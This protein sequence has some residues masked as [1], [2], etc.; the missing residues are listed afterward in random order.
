[1]GVQLMVE[2]AVSAALQ[3]CDPRQQLPAGEFQD[4]LF[5]VCD[6]VAG[7]MQAEQRSTLSG[8]DRTFIERRVS[9]LVGTC[10]NEM[11]PVRFRKSDR[12][13]CKTGSDEHDWASGLVVVVNE[14]HPEDEKSRLPYVV[15]IVPSGRFI[16]VPKDNNCVCRAELCFG[17]R[18][19]ALWF[20]L[21]CLQAQPLR[22]AARRFEV[23][24]RV[25]C[26]VEDDSD[27][28]SIWAA[29][30]VLDVDYSVHADAEKMLPDRNWSG[31]AGRVPYRVGLDSGCKVLVHRDEHWLVRDLALQ[32][33]GPRQSA[34]GQRSLE[35]LERRH[36]GDYT[37]EAIDHETRRVRPCKPPA[38]STDDEHDDDCP[39]CGYEAMPP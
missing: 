27:D 37:F 24:D 38:D 26:A 39:C 16:A 28:Y 11:F 31:D 2:D 10:F 25:A 21:Y 23:G 20:S 1:M 12:V 14:E 36:R 15:S 6:K 3:A 7:V 8:K 32:A 34:N 13:I 22:R 18:A 30:T 33:V 17:Q 5:T 29:G 19:G 4:I 9:K 35:R